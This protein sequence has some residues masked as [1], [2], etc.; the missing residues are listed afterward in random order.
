MTRIC[1]TPTQLSALLRG[2][3]VEILVTMSDEDANAVERCNR[4]REFPNA[5]TNFRDLG[6]GL[7]LVVRADE[8]HTI[9]PPHSIGEVLWCGEELASIS[10]IG[11]C[12]RIDGAR[13]CSLDDIRKWG[14]RME[15]KPPGIVLPADQMPQEAA[16]VFVKVTGVG[17]AK[18]MAY[19][20]GDE[21]E[22][23]EWGPWTIRKWNPLHCWSIAVTP[24][25]KPQEVSE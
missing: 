16:Q 21:T 14:G 4:Y 15:F 20:P 22:P 5:Y 12:Y 6:D 13:C 11:F 18:G 1:P 10:G 19:R 23:S 8:A 7:W 9:R 24:I 17:V 25:E 3:D 2:E